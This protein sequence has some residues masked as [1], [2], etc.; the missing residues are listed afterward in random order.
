MKKIALVSA[1]LGFGMTA[2]GIAAPF[3]Q[4]A[5]PDCQILAEAKMTNAGGNTQFRNTRPVSAS[6]CT[7]EICNIVGG[8]TSTCQLRTSF[9]PKGTSGTSGIITVFCRCALAPGEPTTCHQKLTHN[10]SNNSNA[11]GGWSTECLGV[12][13]PP[14]PVGDCLLTADPTFFPDTVGWTVVKCDCN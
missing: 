6:R 3:F 13:V 2:T 1:A 5:D 4:A 7:I 11:S 12:C 10:S 8:P 14:L 9:T